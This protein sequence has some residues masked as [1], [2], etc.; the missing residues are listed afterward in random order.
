M[1]ANN[2]LPQ[3]EI[4]LWGQTYAGKDWLF[5]SFAKELEFYNL[6]DQDFYYRLGEIQAGSPDPI[7]VSPEPPLN[8]PPTTSFNDIHY[9]FERIALKHD[10]AHDIS[11]NSHD[12]IIHNDKGADLVGSLEDPISFASTYQTLINAK[13]I[14][15]VLSIPGEKV[16]SPNPLSQARVSDLDGMGLALDRLEKR[17]GSPDSEVYSPGAS[18]AT[19]TQE[20]YLKFLQLLFAMLG[21]NPRR[22]LAICMTKADQHRMSGDPWQVF[23]RRYGSSLR[24]LIEVQKNYHQIQIFLTSAAGYIKRAGRAMPNI[25]E[26]VLRDPKRWNPVNTAAPFFWIFQNIE[27][28]RILGTQRRFD[29]QNIMGNGDDRIY[30]PYPGPRNI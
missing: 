15:L 7:P 30:M 24:R 14:F 23:Q 26:G 20:E 27:M 13:H 1:A 5:H 10:R 3:T 18:S 8:I 22:N 17:R 29:I 28:D 12:I 25:E 21:Q 16:A 2:P 6:Y 9:R 19:W 4:A 11:A